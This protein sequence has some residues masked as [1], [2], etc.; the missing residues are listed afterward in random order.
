MKFFSLHEKEQ[1]DGICDIKYYNKPQINIY[2]TFAIKG[3]LYVNFIG[4]RIKAHFRS[5]IIYNFSFILSKISLF[6]IMR[7]KI[8]INI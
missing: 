7:G 4:N 2:R 5:F 6:I 3:S 1:I 8:Y